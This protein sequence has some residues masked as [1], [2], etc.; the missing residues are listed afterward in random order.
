MINSAA[1]VIQI[2][3]NNT[4]AIVNNIGRIKSMIPIKV[5]PVRRSTNP[6]DFA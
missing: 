4:P 3:P 2:S 6:Q 1:Q 5:H